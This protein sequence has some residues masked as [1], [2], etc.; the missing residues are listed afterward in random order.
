[1]ASED[2]V[3]R[4]SD[5]EGVEILTLAHPPVN[6]LSTGLLRRLGERL[7]ELSAGSP[8]AVII[9]GEGQYF[10]AGADL[11]ELASVGLTGAGPTVRAGQALFSRIEAFP[12]PVIAAVNGLAVGGALELILSCDLRV[13]GDSSKFGAP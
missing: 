3:R 12:C 1:M 11:K 5:D 10:S 13:A 8:R 7:D 2:L 6:A 4:R 9:T